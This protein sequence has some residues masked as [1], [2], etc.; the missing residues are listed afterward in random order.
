VGN[1][2]GANGDKKY[3]YRLLVGKPE[4]RRPIAKPRCKWVNK[5]EMN[6]GVRVLGEVD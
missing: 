3:V 6:L 1:E 2:F 5:S 4:G